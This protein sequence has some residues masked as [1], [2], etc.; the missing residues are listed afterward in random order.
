MARIATVSLGLRL[1]GVNKGL[2]PQHLDLLLWL[3]QVAPGSIWEGGLRFLVELQDLIPS[4]TAATEKTGETAP[5]VQADSQA[6]EAQPM[7]TD[8]PGAG[9]A[10]GLED[11]AEKHRGWVPLVYAQANS[12]QPAVLIRQ[13]LQPALPPTPAA[14]WQIGDRVEVLLPCLI[15]YSLGC[16]GYPGSSVM[17]VFSLVVLWVLHAACDVRH[18]VCCRFC[19][20]SVLPRTVTAFFLSLISFKLYCVLGVHHLTCPLQHVILHDG[21]L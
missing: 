8:E 13:P 12:E 16:A 2:G 7:D 3:Q 9:K 20:T 19:T 10:V 11:S 21:M 6:A 17:I 14:D 18:R 15:L 5:N 1:L 4:G